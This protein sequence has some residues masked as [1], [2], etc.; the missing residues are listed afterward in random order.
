MKNKSKLYPGPEWF[1]DLIFVILVSPLIILIILYTIAELII[2]CLW[3][4]LKTLAK[5]TLLPI[6]CWMIIIVDKIK[7]RSV[8]WQKTQNS[9]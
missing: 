6:A 8:K 7:R 2:E 5:Y 1:E 4:I 9:Y 3:A